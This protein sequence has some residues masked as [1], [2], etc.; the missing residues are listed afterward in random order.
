[1]IS[2]IDYDGGNCKSV[3]NILKR[4]N[5]NFVFSNETKHI[6][7]AE[8]I[9]LPGVSNFKYCINNLKKIGLDKIL[10]ENVVIKKKKILGICSGMQILGTHSEEGNIEGL[11]FING[12]V[13]KIPENLKLKVPHMGWNKIDTQNNNLFKDIKNFT[14]FYFCHSFHFE[15]AEKNIIV[16]YT[17]YNIKICA[18]FN[19][20]NIYGVQFH[21]EKSFLEGSKLIKNFCE[22]C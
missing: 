4:L 3:I 22:I 20:N 14:R 9:I 12:Y 8:K 16:N 17:N 2:V 11:N 6:S 18:A 21:P 15:P 10:H 19:Y 1:M 5:I 13:K 7:E